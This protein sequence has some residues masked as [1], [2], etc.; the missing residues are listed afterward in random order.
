[1]SIIPT[2]HTNRHQPEPIRE[3][4]VWRCKTTM[5]CT[6]PQRKVIGAHFDTG[7]RSHAM[8]MQIGLVVT[9]TGRAITQIPID[10]RLL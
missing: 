1:M 6:A 2:R 4:F 9:S 3:S 7:Y 10:R 8:A 5:D